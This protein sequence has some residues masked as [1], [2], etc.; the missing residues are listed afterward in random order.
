MII[1][2][3]DIYYADLRPVVGSR[4]GRD[5]TCPYNTKMMSETDKPDGNLRSN[6]LADA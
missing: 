2:R 3:G 6:N 4:A 1:Q 5:K